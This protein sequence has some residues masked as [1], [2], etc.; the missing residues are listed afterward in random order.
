MR[1]IEIP[2]VWMTIGSIIVPHADIE[3][4]HQGRGTAA[5]WCLADRL[6]LAS[7][8]TIETVRI[9]SEHAA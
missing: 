9:A 2:R 3:T 4:A 1:G 5:Q 8:V 7:F 6:L